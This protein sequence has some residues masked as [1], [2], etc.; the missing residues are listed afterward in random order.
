MG[1]S[2]WNQGGE[3]YDVADI[4]VH[5]DFKPE[6]LSTDFSLIQ[7]AQHIQFGTIARP[8]ALV[9]PN[10]RINAG[11]VVVVSG[12]GET[13]NAAE[14]TLQLRAVQLPI[15]AK[16]KCNAIYQFLGGIDE[17]MICAGYETGGRD[18]CFGDSGSFSSRK[19]YFQLSH[20]HK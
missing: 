15:V 7:L 11:T 12:W 19:F 6:T 2:I 18:S 9:G 3:V 14:S 5:P 10:F 20:S 16:A 1:T 8:I 4:I 17:T 13:L